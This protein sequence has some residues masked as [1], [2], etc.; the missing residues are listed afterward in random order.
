[1]GALSLSLSL[2]LSVSVS[3]VQP[4]LGLSG[5]VIDLQVKGLCVGALDYGDVVSGPFVGFSQRV[6]P[7]VSPVDLASVHGDSERVGQILVTPQHFDQPG[8]VVHGGV[9]R[10]RPEEAL[11]RGIMCASAKRV[12]FFL[13]SFI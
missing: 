4:T 1:M 8:A 10:I 9:D 11:K 3:G 6:S 7:P 2:S 5:R 12:G 13:C